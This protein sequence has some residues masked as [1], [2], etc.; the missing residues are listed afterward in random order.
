MREK[1]LQRRR[2][3]YS[4]IGLDISGILCVLYKLCTDCYCYTLE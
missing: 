4:V 3:G 1:R 2:L